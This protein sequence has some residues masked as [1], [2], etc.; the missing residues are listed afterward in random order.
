M[1]LYE[2]GED[3]LERI[4]MLKEVNESVRSI[5]IARSFHF[6]K[7][8]ISIAMKKLKENGYIEIDEKGEIKLTKQGLDIATN[9]YDRHKTLTKLLIHIGVSENQAKIDACKLEH[10]LSDETFKKLKELVNNIK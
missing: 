5:D 6:S 2:S 7:A 1:E 3:Y 10:D 9:I 4:L 8:S